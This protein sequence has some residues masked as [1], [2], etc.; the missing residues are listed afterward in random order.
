MEKFERRAGEPIIQSLLDIDFYKFSMGQW[1]F[2][3]YPDV[4]VKFGLTNRTKGILLADSIPEKDLR[5]ELDH[6]RALRFN[7]SELHYLRG[8]NEYGYRMFQENYLE[9]LS[10]LEL[11]E[12]SLEKNSEGQYKLEFSGSWKAVTYWETL[13]L[14]IIS[15]LYYESQLKKLSQF[16]RDA[17]YAEGILRLDRKIKSLLEHPEIIFSDF[18][19]RRRFGRSWQDYEV[20]ALASRVSK[21]QFRGTSNVYLAMKHGLLPMGTSAHELGMV[22]AAIREN[23]SPESLRESQDEAFCS[24]W[25]D[26]GVGLSIALTDTFGSKFFFRTASRHIA[27]EWKGLRQDSG[28]PLEFAKM[29][30]EWYRGH[31][32]DPKKKTIIFSDQQNMETMLKITEAIKDEIMISFGWGTDLTNDLGYK[33]LSLVIKVVEADG[34]PAVKLSDNLAKA[35]GDSETVERYKKMAGYKISFWEDCR[36]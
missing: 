7:N 26:Y 2:H 17:V 25:N 15:E 16:Q 1:I 4:K 22:L 9:F 35:M 34:K 30:M 24:W 11:P 14:S 20:A 6:I 21:T 8:T 29:A 31:G 18:G 12:Y 5:G 27:R 13:A 10:K 32:I 28:N 3:R 23:G 36:S 19:T 33:P